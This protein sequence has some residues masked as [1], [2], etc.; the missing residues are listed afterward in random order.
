MRLALIPNFAA[1]ESVEAGRIPVAGGQRVQPPK[2]KQHINSPRAFLRAVC[3]LFLLRIFVMAAQ[4]GPRTVVGK[5]NSSRNALKRG[6]YTNAV[7][8]GEDVQALEELA[9]NIPTLT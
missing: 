4:T 8:A 9:L 6:I 2:A 5:I 7:L 3:I 1:F